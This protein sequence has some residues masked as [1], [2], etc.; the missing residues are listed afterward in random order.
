MLKIVERRKIWFA[1]SLI[2]I[3]IG[4]GS[5]FTRGLEYGIDFKG[6]TVVD[7]SMGKDFNKEDVDQIIKKYSKDFQTNKVNNT[8]VEIKSSD[9]TQNSISEITKEIKT[10][11]K[12]SN[13]TNQ[14]SIGSSIGTETRVK[15]IQAIIIANIIILVYIGMRF[16]FKFGFAAICALVHDVLIML[17]VYS[18]FRIPVD[19]SFIAAML[20]VIGYSMSD[21]IVVFDRI[22]ENQKYMRRVDVVTLADASITQ[23]I[24]RSINTV[25]TVLIT[26]TAVFV[27]VPSIRN[28][29]KPLLVGIVSGCYSSI[30]IASPLWVVFKKMA[31]NK[32]RRALN[33]AK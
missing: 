11:Y 30:F 5:L 26:L 9:L 22:R 3:V 18:I 1:I 13:L 24:A 19:S 12:D 8:S 7:I 27:F 2:I 16:E 10:K 17:T 28:F 21:T 32:K 6:G 23:T 20:T 29:S 15:A 33:T 25:L 31:A 14:E 4:L